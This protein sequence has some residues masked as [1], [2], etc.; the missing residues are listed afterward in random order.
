VLRAR[1]KGINKRTGHIYD[2]YLISLGRKIYPLKTQL[3]KKYG[4]DNYIH[5]I[6]EYN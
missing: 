3:I 4:I 5:L 2:T 6:A 1:F